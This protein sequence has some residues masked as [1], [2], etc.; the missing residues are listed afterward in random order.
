MLPKRTHGKIS[1]ISTSGDWNGVWNGR[2]IAGATA[3]KLRTCLQNMSHGVW[4][5]LGVQW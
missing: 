5:E 4:H 2:E 1:G 3:E